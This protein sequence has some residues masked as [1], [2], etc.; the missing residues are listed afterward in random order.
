M[1]KL[2][3]ADLYKSFH[4]MY[5]FIFMT[6]MAVLAVFLNSVLAVAHGSLEDSIGLASTLLVYPLFLISMF[7]DIVMAE[8][9][10]E[11]TVKNTISYGV[12]RTQ[13]LLA[14]M[15]GTVLVAF[16]VAFVTVS[17]Y[18]VSA[19]ALLRPAKSDLAPVLS[20]FF[21]RLGVALLIYL[22]AAVLAALLA[23]VVKRNAMFTFAYFGILLVPVL[24]FKLMNLLDPFFGRMMYLTMFMQSQVIAAAPQ[25]Q[26]WY[27]VCNAL[28]HLAVFLTVGLVVFR[29]QEI[30]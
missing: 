4:R 29:K 18:M 17:V 16:S 27:A 1:L 30:N 9:N 19:F 13:L 10:K 21:L 11:H 26:L 15:I 23:A 6:V 22:A 25:E 8:E 2:I 7:A 24:L 12:T 28:I 14:K 3:R 5:L 20:D